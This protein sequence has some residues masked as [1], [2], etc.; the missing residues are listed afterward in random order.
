MGINK[1]TPNP[2]NYYKTNFV[3]L[4]ELITP[5]VYKEK[6]L[7]LSGTELNPIS[8]LVNRHVS[9]GNNI[10]NVFSISGVANTQT[11]SLGSISGIAPYFVKQNAL[12]NINPYL[13]ETKILLPLGS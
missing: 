6:D 13:F 4:V 11:S 5:E 3:E 1:Y 12:T 10:S 2:R 9:L 7:E 8:D